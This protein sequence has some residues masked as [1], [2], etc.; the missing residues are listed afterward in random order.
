MNKIIF[1][2]LVLSFC[3]CAKP[4]IMTPEQTTKAIQQLVTA[5]NALAKA[6]NIVEARVTKLEPAPK[7]TPAAKK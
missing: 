3:G 5:H 7:V 1:A 6:H 4:G 2:A